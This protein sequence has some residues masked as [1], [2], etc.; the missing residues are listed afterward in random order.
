MRNDRKIFPSLF[1]P[2]AFFFILLLFCIP[3][4]AQKPVAFVSGKLLDEKEQPL[5]KVSIIILGRETGIV[6]SDS[7]TFRLR[8][9]AD[10]AFALIFSY[11]GY[12][13]VQQNFLLN[14]KEEERVLIRMENS[15]RALPDVIVH[16]EQDRKEAGLIRL[17]P[18]DAVNIPSPGG[19][20]ENLIKVFVGSTNELT[21]QYSVRG[22]NYDENLIYVND[23]EI[24]R[25]YLVSNAQQEGLSFINPDM[26]RNVSF[27]NGGFQAKYGDKISSVLDIQYKKPKKFGGSVYAGLLE[28]GL[29]LEGVSKNNRFTY[30]IGMRNRDYKNLLSAQE[31]KGNYAPSSADIQGLFTYRLSNGNSLELFSV[32]SQTA[33]HLIPQSAQLST[34]VFSP[35]FSSNLALD[36]FFNGQEKDRYQT[37]ILGLT[38]NQQL[39]RDLKLKWII[40]LFNDHERESYDITGDYLFGERDFDKTSADYG[41][42]VNPLGSGVYQNYARN[43]LNITVLDFT[44]KGYL[45]RGNHYVQWGLSAKQ[46]TVHDQ[47]MQWQYQDSAGYSLPNQPGSLVLFSS[48][49]GHSDLRTGRF[50]GFVQ[51]NISFP[52]VRA[53]TLQVGARINYNTLNRELLVSPRTGFSWKPK[54]SIRDVVYRGAIGIYDQPPFYRELRKPDG[55]IN[56]ELKAQKS[57]QVT[58]GA[59]FNFHAKDKPF[60]LSVEAYY[61]SL[62][63]V[64][65]YDVNNVHI[66]YFGTNNAKAYAMGIEGR[67]FGN[68]VKDAES[69][70]SIGLMRTREKIDGAQFYNYTLDSLNHPTDST[71]VNQGW[72]RRPTDRLLTFGMFIQDYLSTNKNFKVYLSLLYGGNLPFNIPGSAKYRNALVIDP[73][74]RADIGFSALLLDNDKSNR[75]SHNPFRNLENIWLSLEIFNLIDR[76]NTISYLLIKDFSNTTYAMPQRLTPRLINLKVTTRF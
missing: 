12:K 22:G 73:Y 69:W 4:F 49:N 59:D 52:G 34:A 24:F 13:T 35:Y 56:K 45:N 66:Q 18:K 33:F 48:Q 60:R 47:L 6:S 74:I 27:Y 62:W 9:P 10:K 30:L 54:N 71:L 11:T 7:G 63:D 3:V 55:T 64:N 58:A 20:I 75:R 68:L 31:T 26:T 2:A 41:T 51:D 17:N 44:H 5:A 19:S 23:I 67:L 16:D 8:V 39:D 21:S 37:G 15:D 1:I 38:W 76:E 25:P 53:F 46:E 65:P 32:Y 14:D 43:L 40:S 72:I 28:Q 61:K 29:E 42:I 50:T 70:I 57:W 36:V